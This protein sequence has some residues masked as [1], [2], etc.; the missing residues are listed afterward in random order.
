[1]KE[2]VFQRGTGVVRELGVVRGVATGDENKLRFVG[3]ITPDIPLTGPMFVYVNN[4]PVWAC[5]CEKV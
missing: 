4:C 5:R 3:L 1:M 2:P